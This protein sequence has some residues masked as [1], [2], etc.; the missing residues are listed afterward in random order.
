MG[1]EMIRH[2]EAILI[3][4]KGF[5][6]VGGKKVK[7][8]IVAHSETGHHHVAVGDITTYP[9]FDVKAIRESLTKSLYPDTEITGLFRVD[10]ESAELRHKKDFD[11]HETKSLFKGLY[12]VAIKRQFDYFTKMIERVRD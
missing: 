8:L 2:G 4:V 11:R 6:L 10:G 3:P 1:A 12:I 7:E 5:K 9:S